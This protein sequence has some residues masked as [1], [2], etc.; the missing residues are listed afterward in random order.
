MT[1]SL[2]Q[3]LSSLIILGLMV[4]YSKGVKSTVN[5]FYLNTDL[6]NVFYYSKLFGHILFV[7]Y[8]Y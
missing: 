2:H 6:C 1:G 8:P 3:V 5:T 7:S 4:L